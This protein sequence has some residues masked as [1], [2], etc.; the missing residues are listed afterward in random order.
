MIE[1][2]DAERCTSCDICVNVCPTNVF[3]K[4]DGIPVIAR[5][6]R[7]GTPPLAWHYSG[8]EKRHGVSRY[9]PAAAPPQLQ[10]HFGL[11][12][13]VALN[14]SQIVGAGVIIT[15]P[16]MIKQ[17]PGAVRAARLAGG[18]CAHSGG[19]TVLV[20]AGG[21]PARLRRF[22]RLPAGVLRT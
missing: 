22:V 3:D 7:F 17:L 15:I 1:V 2:I 20:R 4:T 21:S 13:A 14:V 9:V 11:V 6:N 12:H 18:W 8:K 19:R 10:R 16:L 5:Q